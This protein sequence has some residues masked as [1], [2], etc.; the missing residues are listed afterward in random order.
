MF[1]IVLF[2]DIYI[3]TLAGAGCHGLHR[4]VVPFTTSYAVIAYHH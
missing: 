4:M 1:V 3:F 2:L